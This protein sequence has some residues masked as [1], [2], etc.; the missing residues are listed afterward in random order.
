M[1]SEAGPAT[2]FDLDT[3]IPI[4]EPPLTPEEIDG[5]TQEIVAAESALDTHVSTLQTGSEALNAQTFDLYTDLNVAEA[6]M[7]QQATANSAPPDDGLTEGVTDADQAI[8]LAAEAIP[9]IG[10]AEPPSSIN[11]PPAPPMPPLPR[12]L[13]EP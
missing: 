11:Y 8:E 4:A 7:S 12:G 10:S 1:E 13:L 6:E 9:V 2:F 3:A 5:S